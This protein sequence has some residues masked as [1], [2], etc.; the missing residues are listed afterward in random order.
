[1]NLWQVYIAAI[2]ILLG[3]GIYCLISRKNLIQ[4]II[5]VEVIAKAVTLSFILAGHLQG[6]EQI[7]QAI[8]VTIILI[9]AVCTAVA[10]SLV[11]A[12]YRHTGSLDINILKRL[13][14]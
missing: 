2:V 10:L 13:R 3:I 8:V 1:M 7:A 12:A 9:E 14:G 5:G 4:L 6:N 11:V